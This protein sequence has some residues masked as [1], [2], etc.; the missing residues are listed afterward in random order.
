MPIP[1][2]ETLPQW[3]SFLRTLLVRGYHF[4]NGIFIETAER[5]ADAIL[6]CLGDFV[7]DEDTIKLI[8]ASKYTT[9]PETALEKAGLLRKVFGEGNQWDEEESWAYIKFVRLNHRHVDDLAL[10][11]KNS[12]T[13]SRMS[14]ISAVLSE[15]QGVTD[16]V[17][18]GILE[19][20][21][22]LQHGANPGV[23]VSQAGLFAD[24]SKKRLDLERREL[25][26]VESG[27]CV[28]IRTWIEAVWTGNRGDTA[29]YYGV[30]RYPLL[31]SRLRVD[32]TTARLVAECG[33]FGLIEGPTNLNVIALGDMN[34][35]GVD[36]KPM[37]DVLEMDASL[38]VAPEDQVTPALLHDAGYKGDHSV[39][40]QS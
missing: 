17:A 40:E 33:L 36:L 11:S 5:Y 18:R 3:Q 37:L 16:P 9:D 22:V 12:F 39:P 6:E 23:S 1:Q 8:V 30:I 14:K 26:E 19:T 35:L 28:K 20:A 32:L 13:R 24:V 27:A 29:R 4:K 2:L 34:K 10:R 21:G 7:N 31:A 38:K 15:K 25:S